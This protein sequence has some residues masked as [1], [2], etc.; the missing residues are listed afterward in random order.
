[1]RPTSATVAPRRLSSWAVQRPMPLPPPVTIITWPAN[2]SVAENRSGMPRGACLATGSDPLPLRPVSYATGQTR[3]LTPSLDTLAF[4]R[5][6]SKALPTPPTSRSERPRLSKAPKAPGL[7]N[8]KVELASAH[9]RRHC[10]R[11]RLRPDRARLR[12]DLQSHRDGEFRPGRPDDA[13]RLP[14]AH[15]RRHHGDELLA[16]LPAGGPVHGGVRLS[17]RCPGAAAHHRPAAV[18]HRHPHDQPGLPVPRRRRLHLGPRDPELRDAL[19]Q[20][21]HQR[22]RRHPAAR[23]HLDDR[24]HACC[25]RARSISSSTSP[26]SAMPCRPPPRTSWRPTTWASP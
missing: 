7:G 16:G 20:P 11:L 19:H 25:W 15:L 2:R 26:R 13:G 6:Q 5:R 21:H 17:A 22:G 8:G 4:S 18:R 14:G 9:R 24:R 1:M 12:A 10:A 3:G 23:E